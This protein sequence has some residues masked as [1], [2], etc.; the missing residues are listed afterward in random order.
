MTSKN[1]VCEIMVLA[2]NGK[3]ISVLESVRANWRGDIS[4]V[5]LIDP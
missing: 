4:T 1:V 2:K 5:T 3:K